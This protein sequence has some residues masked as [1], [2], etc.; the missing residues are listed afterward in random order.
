[1]AADGKGGKVEKRRLGRGLSSLL[2]Q[3]VRVDAAGAEEA[4]HG[5]DERLESAQHVV[6]KDV[7]HETTE[8]DNSRMIRMIALAEIGPNPLQ[9]RKSFR[10]SGLNELAASIRRAGVM[11]PVLLRRVQAGGAAVGGVGGGG[12]GGGQVA[13]VSGVSEVESGGGGRGEGGGGAGGSGGVK[14]A[15]V[16]GER[17]W[18]AAGIAGLK[19]IP[20]IVS[21]LTDMEAAEWAL[22]ENV[23][24]ED[25]NTM[26]RAE[27]MGVLVERFG[28]TQSQVA[29][30]LGMDRVSV[31]HFIRLNNLDEM[32]KEDVRQG[33]LTFGHAK[34]LLGL[35]EAARRR[36][37]AEMIMRKNWSVRDAEEWVERVHLPQ[38][39]AGGGDGIG[40]GRDG[41]GGAKAGHIVEMER[42]I[43]EAVGLP[44]KMQLMRRKR[45]A[46]RM[47]ITF[48]NLAEF[49]RLARLLKGG[50]G[51]GDDE[52]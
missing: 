6:P 22:I 17:R 40:G 4:G 35:G 26:D 28:L 33:R 41:A 27:A 21:E 19:E 3:T 42:E 38:L 30:R 10:E 12:G 39:S 25:L 45:N 24:R 32:T 50:K 16:A 1:M 13:G 31:T 51:A 52:E 37:L 43:S 46:G 7:A 2:G 8:S 36:E 29:D 14:Y 18:R 9:P 5:R 48:R 47:V 23:Q 49:E 11:Q 44:V 34:A 15:L 20:A